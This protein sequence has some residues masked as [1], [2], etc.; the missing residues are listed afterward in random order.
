MTVS[1]IL[2]NLFII[3]TKN[4]YLIIK[5]MPKTKNPDLQKKPNSKA[6]RQTSN[7]ATS[8]KPRKRTSKKTLTFS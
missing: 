1:N 5:I 8:S 3:V 2:I 7:E 4:Y 6:P